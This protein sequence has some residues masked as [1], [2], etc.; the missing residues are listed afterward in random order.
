MI[1]ARIPISQSDTPRFNQRHSIDH[2]Y[3]LSVSVAAPILHYNIYQCHLL[4]A[5]QNGISRAVKKRIFK[6]AQT[7]QVIPST[8][9]PVTYLNGNSDLFD[10]L[11]RGIRGRGSSCLLT[12]TILIPFQKKIYRMP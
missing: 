3:S 5:D 12:Q 8:R 1:G 11:A 10:S 9:R 2:Y 4:G 6:R 7:T